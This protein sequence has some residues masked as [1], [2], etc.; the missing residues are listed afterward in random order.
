[1]EIQALGTMT[2]ST[3]LQL[4]TAVLVILLCAFLVMWAKFKNSGKIEQPVM[5]AGREKGMMA[6]GS[7]NYMYESK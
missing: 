7:K 1:M 2:S 3:I 5:E 6:L 4:A